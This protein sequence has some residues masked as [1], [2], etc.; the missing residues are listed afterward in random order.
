MK[1]IIQ[2]LNQTDV[3]LIET[4]IPKI[5]KNNILVKTN[6]SLISSGTEKML[7]DFAKANLLE[8]AK[9]QPDKLQEVLSKLNTDGIYATYEA[10]SSKMDVPLEMGYCNVGEVIEVG[11]N[12]KGKFNIGDRIVSNGPHA[13]IISTHEKLCATIPDGVS[14]QDAVFTV[15]GSIS[16]HGIRCITP[17]IGETF[18]VSGLGIIGLLTC[19]ILIANGCKVL[20][21]DPDETKCK[22][23]EKFGVITNHIDDENFQYWIKDNTNNIGIDGALIT[24]STRSSNPIKQ[25]ANS[26][27]KRGRIVMIGATGMHLNRNDFYKNEISFMVSCSYGPG[28]YD[29][30]YEL[31]GLDY[32]IG[33]VRWTEKRNFQAILDLIKKGSID[34]KELI[35]AK[36]DLLD[37]K[38]AYK[39][40]NSKEPNLAILLNYPKKENKKSTIKLYDFPQNSELKRSKNKEKISISFIGSGNYASRL[41]IPA[42]KKSNVSFHSL[43]A[44]RGVN[45]VHFGKKFG[46]KFSSTNID[47]VIKSK[48][49]NTIVIATRHDSH[50]DL[51]I[52]S[53]E[54]GKNVFVEKP[55]CINIEEL[56]KI[57]ETYMKILK[58]RKKQILMVGFNR[59]F[60]PLTVSLKNKLSNLN[61][62]QAFIYT[63]N[64]GKLDKNNWQFD[65]KIG[66][67]RLIGEAC[68]FVDLMRFLASSKIKKIN[69]LKLNKEEDCFSLN[70]E[71]DNGSIGTIHYFSNGSKR[72]PKERLEVFSNGEIYCINNFKSF[73]VWDNN[74]NYKKERL[75]KQN[76]GQNECVDKFIE[77][78]NKGLDSPIPIDQLFEV[79][80]KL[81]E[82]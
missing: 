52:K 65:P 25:A 32:P 51:V 73:E 79:Q 26:C 74:L 57:R 11:E 37:A 28:R 8:K 72:F 61:S 22:I 81:L 2:Y 60:S 7:T 53:L 38:K 35:S 50:A 27:R 70:I 42:F 17:S 80:Q 78:I 55:I 48:D 59:R 77:S 64:A 4:P 13:E 9:Q 15:L 49:V 6:L 69:I 82:I 45:T 41:L 5:N 46:F 31:K 71:F 58:K 14:D 10:V 18:L 33:Y 1:Q 12:C 3:T 75:F 44:N 43:S 40:L 56:N 19:Q 21:F 67:G 36:F 47:Q 29:D 63:C 62:K 24:A 23:A 76:K 39:L 68:H 54:A 20:G 66:G 34:T 16:L 30:Q